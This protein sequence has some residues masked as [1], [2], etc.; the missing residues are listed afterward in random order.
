MKSKLFFIFLFV[1]LFS[2]GQEA[3]KQIKRVN[4]VWVGYY[5]S[6]ILNPN[7]T[8]ISDWQFRTKD[9]VEHN[10][11]ALGRIGVNYKLNDKYS[12]SVGLAHFRFYLNDEVTRGEW[13]PW[14]ELAVNDNFKQLKISQRFRVEERF[15]QRTDKNHL[16]NSYSFNWRFRY[17]LDLQY[18]IAKIGESKRIYLTLGNEILI[19][20]GKEIVYNYF[21]QN[22]TSAG[23][24]IEVTRQISLQP[25]F[26]YIWQQESNGKVLDQ[27]NVVRFNLIHKIKV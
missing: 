17:K 12:I 7:W 22:R 18:P 23:F 14:Q 2:F 25:Q 26:I 8:V 19:N 20:A 15:N 1:T 10:S 11:Q 9:W 16:V 5:N 6:V 27:I 4:Q 24:L 3:G 21:D 13:R